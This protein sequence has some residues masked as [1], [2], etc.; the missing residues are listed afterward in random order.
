MTDTDATIDP[1]PVPVVLI[2][3]F[4]VQPDR[5]DALIDLLTAMTRA[6]VGLPG[7]VSATLHRGLNG[8][9]VANHA[10]WRSVADWKAMT[11][12]PAVAAA[13]SPIMAIATF[14][15]NLYEAGEVIE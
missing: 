8:K 15:P 6:Q 14:E 2:N 11:R 5:Q 12:N 9:T 1:D 4:K 3:V 7:F 13:M 10:V